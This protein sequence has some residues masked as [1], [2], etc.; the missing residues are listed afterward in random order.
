MASSTRAAAACLATVL[1]WPPA[2]AAGLVR[3]AVGREVSVPDRPRRIV[4]MA[5]NLTEILFAIGLGGS[6]V[7]V[8]DFCDHPP[9]ARA[10]PRIGGFVNPSLETI[11]A[12][13]PDLVLATADGNR[14]ADVEALAALG[15]AVYTTDT[16]SLDQVEGTIREIGRIAGAAQRAAALAAG[17]A[18]RRAR[19]ADRVRGREPVSVFVALD[20]RPLV[21]AAG[22]TFVGELV[23]VAG[24]RN[25]AAGSAVAYPVF[26][27]E[28]LLEADPEA[29]VD[30]A[31]DGPATPAEARRRWEELPGAA[32]LRAVR[33]GRI[34]APGMGDFFLPGPRIV[35]S[36]ETLARWL[37]PEDAGR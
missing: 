8:T 9:E 2:A 14:R 19:V 16:R 37:H 33:R 7:G 4:S 29:I 24:G 5:P 13:A 34:L 3:D 31:G 1:L 30:A 18:A 20:R 36:L 6:V 11:A 22:G 17:I 10:L 23:A 27:L 25:V 35:E 26:S 21:S 15:I 28:R 12:L 32:S